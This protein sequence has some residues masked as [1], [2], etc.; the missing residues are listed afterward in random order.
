MPQPNGEVQMLQMQ[1]V[2]RP[3]VPEPALGNDAPRP[4]AGQQARPLTG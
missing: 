3:V 1:E 4:Q 2:P